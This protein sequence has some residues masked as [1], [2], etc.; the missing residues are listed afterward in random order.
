MKGRQL[1]LIGR[2][3]VVDKILLSI[4]NNE[5]FVNN[6]TGLLHYPNLFPEGD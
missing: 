2:G 5:V 6:M 4:D 1:F 3:E